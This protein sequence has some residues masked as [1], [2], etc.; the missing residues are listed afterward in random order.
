MLFRSCRE[1]GIQSL[2][3]EGLASGKTGQA[4]GQGLYD[5]SAIDPDGF[6]LRKQSPYFSEVK[7]WNMPG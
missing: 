7:K 5:W 2:V 1:T 6:R 3:K 4:A